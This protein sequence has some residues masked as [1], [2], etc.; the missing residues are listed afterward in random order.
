M[1]SPSEGLKID[2]PSRRCFISEC[3][4]YCGNTRTRRRPECKQ[5]DKAKSTIRYRPPNGTAG[6]ARSDV[7]G[8]SREPTPPAKTKVTVWSSIPLSRASDA[9]VASQRPWKARAFNVF[10][11]KSYRSR[12][13]RPGRSELQAGNFRAANG[14]ELSG[15][16]T[17]GLGSQRFLELHSG[18]CENRRSPKSPRCHG[19][20]RLLLTL[21]ATSAPRLHGSQ[22]FRRWRVVCISTDPSVCCQERQERESR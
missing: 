18:L 19:I 6:L 3:D 21:R 2:Q 15:G 17:Q 13:F 4:L 12:C 22:Q 8:C 9:A 11:V 20:G 16:R 1:Y 7:R 5:F 10:G 14:R